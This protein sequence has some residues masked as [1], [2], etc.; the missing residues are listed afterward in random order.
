[1]AP[2]AAML[3]A[4]GCLHWP[5]VA[6]AAAI[7]ALRSSCT[8]ASKPGQR[9]ACS[10]AFVTDALHVMQDIASA[11]CE[12][13]R[14]VR[15]VLFDKTP[16]SNWF[17]PWHQDRTIAVQQRVELEGFGPWSVKDGMTH[18]EPPFAIMARMVTL[19]LHLDDCGPGNAPLHVAFGSHHSRVA[20]DDAGRIAAG[21][22]QMACVAQAGDVWAYATPIVHRSDRAVA[23]S[24]RRVLQVDFSPDQLAG[25]LAWLA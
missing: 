24:R 18:V 11:C 2:P 21:S 19:R 17:V 22:E 3:A 16:G 5:Q 4:R 20:A 14:P 9:Y 6:S 7:A 25:G 15:A 10:S 12:G 13:A 1:M 8:T 23:P